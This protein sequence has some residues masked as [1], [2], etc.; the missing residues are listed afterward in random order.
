M[1]NLEKLVKINLR[2]SPRKLNVLKYEARK[3]GCSYNY[4]IRC[5]IREF[6]DRLPPVPEEGQSCR[7]EEPAK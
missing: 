4:L 2:V 5:A 7:T 1:T 3:R 6:V